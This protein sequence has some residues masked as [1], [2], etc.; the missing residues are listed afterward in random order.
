M[1][2]CVCFGPA[3]LMRAFLCCC[4]SGAGC[5]LLWFEGGGVGGRGK[6]EGVCAGGGREGLR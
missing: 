2:V 4:N 6:E 3:L 5:G 1:C